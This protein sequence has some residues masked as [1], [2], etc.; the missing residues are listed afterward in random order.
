MTEFTPLPPAEVLSDREIQRALNE[1]GRQDDQRLWQAFAG[2]MNDVAERIS[3]LIV[4]RPEDVARLAEYRPVFSVPSV[5]LYP[6]M[7]PDEFPD[8]ASGVDAYLDKYWPTKLAHDADPVASADIPINPEYERAWVAGE[9]GRLVT[10]Q[11]I[12][13]E[14]DWDK[15]Q[16]VHRRMHEMGRCPMRA[17]VY[18]RLFGRHN[19]ES[20]IH[21]PE[22]YFFNNQMTYRYDGSA[23]LF[24]GGWYPSQVPLYEG[25]PYDG[26]RWTRAIGLVGELMWYDPRFLDAGKQLAAEYGQLLRERTL[27]GH[28]VR[29]KSE[30]VLK[31]TADES[32]K[33]AV[34]PMAI[35]GTRL[36][37]GSK[38]QG[39]TLARVG[40]DDIPVRLTQ[41]A[42]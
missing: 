14:T 27:R 19:A 32:Y 12:I 42:S 41:Q 23:T 1:H 26:E 40:Y 2:P 6:D 17:T 3:Q 10:E 38:V 20:N 15:Y 30:D 36:A 33:R 34:S 31:I 13:R 21:G 16:D 24:G 22:H 8:D 7:N 39:D 37:P 25:S 28:D 29:W 35:E 5:A 18:N 9:L 11:T 4:E